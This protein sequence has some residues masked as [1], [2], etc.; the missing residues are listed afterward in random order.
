MI[1][2]SHSQTNP[3]DDLLAGQKIT[4]DRQAKSPTLDSEKKKEINP[5]I[6]NQDSVKLVGQKSKSSQTGS[7]S[8][9]R[10]SL[11]KLNMTDQTEDNE[12]LRPKKLSEYIGQVR[13]VKQLSLI[14]ESSKIRGKLPEHIL[15]Y[16]QPGLGKTTL[17]SL[18]AYELKANTKSISAPALQKIGDVVSLMVNLEPNTVLFIDEIHR[19]RAPLEETLYTAMEDGEVDLMLGKGQGVS[20]MKI[21]L[22]PF[23]L[24][25]ATTQLGKLSKPLKDRFT[26]IF[27]LEAYHDAEML[28]LIDRTA[29]ILRLNLDQEAKVV[30]CRRS[31]GVPRV[32]NNILKRFLDL[33]TVYGIQTINKAEAEDFLT[34][35]GIFEK[36]LTKSDLLYLK[37]LQESSL[38]LKTLS[39]ILLEEVETIESVIEPYL[40]HL[41]FIDKDSTGRKLTPRGKEYLDRITGKLLCL[42]K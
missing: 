17:A 42:V 33:Q 31:R 28:E 1:V 27:Q 21:R 7:K 3:K 25:G 2:S 23:V 4:D 15:F 34:E 16:G 18:I 24:I 10:S 40:I 39:G 13:L 9:F 36:G 8:S 6:P 22:N 5:S 19:L 32:A 29:K 20:S 41:G 37:S 30:V 12:T 35:L 14:L 26:N 11:G 38:G